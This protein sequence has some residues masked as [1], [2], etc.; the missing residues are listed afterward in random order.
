[1]L[2]RPFEEERDDVS[3]T[4]A[5]F[6]VGVESGFHLFQLGFGGAM[7]Q[8]AH[9]DGELAGR[10]GAFVFFVEDGEEFLVVNEFFLG[11]SLE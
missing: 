1:M 3:E 5:A 4:N 8:P 6:I 2:L 7:T 10:N 11:Q 9:E